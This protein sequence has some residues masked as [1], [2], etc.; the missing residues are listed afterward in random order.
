MENRR[1]EIARAH[2]DHELIEVMMEEEPTPR[3]EG[4]AGG[5]LQADIATQAELEQVRDPEAHEGV[6]KGDKVGHGEESLPRH[7]ADKTP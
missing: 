2:D 6:K 4:K 3:F 1:T 7:P 5:S